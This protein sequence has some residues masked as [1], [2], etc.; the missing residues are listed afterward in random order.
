MDDAVWEDGDPVVASF[1]VVD[2]DSVIVEVYVFYAE[3]EAFHE[4][5][6]ASV[7][8]LG[9]EFVGFFHAG[10]D[11][12]C[13]GDGEDVWYPF[14]FFGAYEFE[15]GFI[16]WYFEDVAVEEHDGAD[17][18]VLGG[19]GGFALDDEVCDE[20]VDL[21]YAHFF[22]VA[23]VVVEDVFADPLEVGFFGAVGVLFEA[24]FFA[25]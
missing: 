3:A 5:E 6:A 22:G 1:A 17:G 13:F 20:L 10:D 7:H 25:V 12:F 19:G 4:S 2:E 14:S 11:V 8:D 23:F 21:V 16:Q 18:L 9:H 24:D 15:P